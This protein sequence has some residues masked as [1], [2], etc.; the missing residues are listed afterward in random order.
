MLVSSLSRI[1]DNDY[2][3]TRMQA[4]YEF[5]RTA[6]LANLPLGRIDIDGDDVFANVQEYVSVPASKKQMEAH[7]CYYDVQ[8]VVTGE[9]RMEVAPLEGLVPVAAFDE[10]ADFGLYET[11]E[12]P[13]VVILRAGDLAVVAPEDAH[14]PGCALNSPAP[15]RKVV[16]KVR[17]DA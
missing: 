13:S 7:R 12:A 4:A 14:K 3:S 11:P 15:V 9:E 2:L 8:Y 16:V 6:D 1:N 5:L 10:G 17:I